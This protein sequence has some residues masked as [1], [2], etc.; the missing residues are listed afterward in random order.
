MT[1]I[2]IVLVSKVQCQSQKLISQIIAFIVYSERIVKIHHFGNCIFV[3]AA[4]LNGS[5]LL[6]KGFAPLGDIISFK[7][8]LLFGIVLAISLKYRA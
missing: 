3:F 8:R 4:V 2:I 5:Q 1:H 6:N 7:T